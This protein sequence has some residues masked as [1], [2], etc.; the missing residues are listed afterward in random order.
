MSAID[1]L[2][3]NVKRTIFK[4]DY[5]MSPYEYIPYICFKIVKVI[6]F[7]HMKNYVYNH[8][9]KY[10]SGKINK[11]EVVLDLGSRDGIQS[12]E[13]SHYFPE[14]KIYSFECNPP[15]IKTLRKN[16]KK[17]ENIHVIPKAVFNENKQMEF[18]PV[19]TSNDGASSLFKATG[20]YDV[21]E[22]FPQT[23]VTVESIRLD[24]WAEENNIDK[25]DLCWLDLQGAA[26]DALVGM[27]EMI[28]D[29]QAL[30]T[31]VEFQEI[32]SGQ[33]LFPELKE[34]LE[35]KGFALLRLDEVEKNWW[36]NA[37]FINNDLV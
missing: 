37:I 34:F 7:V 10:I 22:N 19:I 9:L 36:G 15:T 25:F 18:F 23:K 12:I 16:T 27:G 8:F 20:K 32:Y 33:K 17:Y 30:Y 26:Y 2:L 21:V 4:I 11:P 3:R 13:L 5:F 29:V 28:H 24:K 6:Y 1:S 31:E 35:K 14:A